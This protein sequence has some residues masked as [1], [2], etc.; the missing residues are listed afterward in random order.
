MAALAGV[1]AA[2]INGP[3][4]L[5]G[6]D[7]GSLNFQV[8]RSVMVLEPD[9]GAAQSQTEERRLAWQQRSDLLIGWTCAIGT[10]AGAIATMAV[11]GYAMAKWWAYSAAW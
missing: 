5:I 8:R 6:Q 4:I 11:V 2:A 9:H 1:P 10:V 3:L 7:R